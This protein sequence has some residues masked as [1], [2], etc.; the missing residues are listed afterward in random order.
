[1]DSFEDELNIEK[2]DCSPSGMYGQCSKQKQP[3]MEKTIFGNEV[4][5]YARDR[6]LRDEFAAKAMVSLME[7]N[8]FQDASERA[9]EMADQ[10]M[11]AREK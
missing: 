10:M 5:I 8:D 2:H 1:M 3:P 9:Y 6:T 11:K 4:I 7:C